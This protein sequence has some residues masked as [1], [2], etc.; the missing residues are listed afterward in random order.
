MGPSTPFPDDL[1]Y[2]EEEVTLL[3]SKIDSSKSSG[4]DGISGQMLKLT[5]Y[6][7]APAITHF[8]NLSLTSGCVPKEWK[9]AWVSPVPK[10]AGT[11]DYIQFR[12]VSLLSLI[13]I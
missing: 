9:C 3:L 7:S 12:P 2:C 5:A 13:H 11:T 6:S 1:L 8:F 4:P 10:V